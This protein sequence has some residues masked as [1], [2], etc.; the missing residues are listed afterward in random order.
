M[1]SILDQLKFQLMKTQLKVVFTWN[2]KAR[3][4]KTQTNFYIE[5]VRKEK[6]QV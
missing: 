4:L 3:N 1:I 5:V 6:C 2:Q